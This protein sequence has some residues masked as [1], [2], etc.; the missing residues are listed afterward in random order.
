VPVA[1][2]SSEWLA[3]GLDRENDSPVIQRSR[4]PIND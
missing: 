4:S 3:A 2:H 1:W